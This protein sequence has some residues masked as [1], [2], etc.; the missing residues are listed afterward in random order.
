[1]TIYCGIDWSEHHHDVAIIDEAGAVLALRRISDDAAGLTV[2]LML[3][4][5]HAGGEQFV[6]VDV[7]IETD[8]GLLVAALR[9]AGH[10]LYEI[11]P[12]AASRYR[13]RHAGSGATSDRKDA[14]VLAHLLRTDRDQHRPMP[15]DSEQVMALGVLA[16]AH[17]DAIAAALRD[18]G[19]LR[20]LLREFFPAAL[21]AFPTLH[22][23]SAV[24]V[25]AAAPTPTAAAQ[26]AVAQLRKLMVAARRNTPKDQ[27]QRLRAIFTAPQLHQ[28]PPVEAAMGQAVTA[29]VRTLAAT[30]ES[31][32]EL[33]AAL[34]EHFEQH[35]DAE[36]LRSLPG[37]GVI[38]GARVLSE[39]GDDP[40]RFAECRQPPGL[41]RKR[42]DHP[43]LRKDPTGAAAPGLQPSPGRRLPMVGVHRNA[44]LARRQR[45]LP[46]PPRRRRQ[47][48]SRTT[49]SGQ[50]A[51]RPAAPLPDPPHALPRTPGLDAGS[52]RPEGRLTT[53]RPPPPLPGRQ[54]PITGRRREG[55]RRP[56]AVAQ[57]CA[58][59]WTITPKTR[60]I[61]P[62]PAGQPQPLTF[63]ADE[64]S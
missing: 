12:K 2:L 61:P 19:R 37:L 11:N 55:P 10:R 7:A 25:L 9:A 13:D 54:W 31:I 22:T 63:N 56:Q 33:E 43:G 46:A 27:P 32:R 4:T 3:L 21:V 38:L 62:H 51:A 59:P 6:P 30:L 41:R 50:Q 44:A 60:T 58:A 53:A 57:R 52:S 14:L 17:Q 47:P 42:S 45:L 24:T 49:A 28:P 39:F 36:I 64:V 23:L 16:R 29:I 8:R 26:L 15:A 5:E 20:S 35:P 18:A 1:M 34:D 40:T 48:R